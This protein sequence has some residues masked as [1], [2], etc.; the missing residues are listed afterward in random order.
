MP[1]LSPEQSI[2]FEAIPRIQAGVP[3]DSTNPSG[4]RVIQLSDMERSIVLTVLQRFVAA[5]ADPGPDGP[6]DSVSQAIARGAMPRIEAA[7][8]ESNG[9]N[10]FRLSAT[11]GGVI[12]AALQNFIATPAEPSPPSGPTPPSGVRIGSV[13]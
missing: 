6:R 11:E 3:V 1:Q 10:S 9:E 12:V 7:T 4:D 8:R 5:P 13:G 2:A